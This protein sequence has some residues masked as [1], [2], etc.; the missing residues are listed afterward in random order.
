MANTSPELIKKVANSLAPE[1]NNCY[2]WNNGIIAAII[3]WA[4]VNERLKPESAKTTFSSIMNDVA[5]LQCFNILLSVHAAK[6]KELA[7]IAE[8]R[9]STRL[10]YYCFDKWV[11][12]SSRSDAEIGLNPQK[13]IILNTKGGRHQAHLV[14]PAEEGLVCIDPT[15][16][17]SEIRLA[18]NKLFDRFQ[19]H[20]GEN[21]IAALIR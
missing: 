1:I 17:S 6:S 13:Y 3:T 4:V 21:I 20:K 12:T 15:N 14:L 11:L 10:G 18:I 9:T 2:G 5:H 19:H 16:P 7:E 8:K